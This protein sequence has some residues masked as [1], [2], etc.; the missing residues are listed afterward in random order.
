MD[1]AIMIM[2]RAQEMHEDEIR[3]KEMHM[4]FSFNMIDHENHYTEI[5]IRNK[6]KFIYM[7]TEFDLSKKVF[8]RIFHQIMKRHMEN[9]REPIRQIYISINTGKSYK[10]FK[11]KLSKNFN[12]AICYR[13][14][15]QSDFGDVKDNIKEF[16]KMVWKYVKSM[17]VVFPK[18]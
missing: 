15:Y 4:T 8:Y 16:R 2:S 11:T 17:K 9:D 5:R 18:P 1:L 6:K 3:S 13:D 10:L 14:L 7:G 12:P